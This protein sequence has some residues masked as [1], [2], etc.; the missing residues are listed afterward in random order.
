[1]F[2]LTEIPPR[3]MVAP[4]GAR[5]GKADNPN[6]PISIEEIRNEAIACAAAGADALHLHIR[7]DAGNHSLD[8]GRYQEAISEIHTTLPQFPIQITTESAGLFDVSQQFNCLKMLRPKA[9]SISV[10]EIARDRTLAPEVYK[11]CSSENIHVQHILYDPKD[12]LQ[13]EEWQN[14]DIVKMGQ[15]DTIFVLGSYT[16]MKAALIADLQD[17]EPLIKAQKG[18]KMVCAFGDN[19]HEVLCAAAAMGFDLRIGFENN[20]SA[21]DGSLAKSNAENVAELKSAINR[22]SP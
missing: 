9:T 17:L 19:E 1:M 15:E 6:I 5:R 16:P 20:I 11:F 18:R 2:A 12:L 13:L 8:P 22:L 4:N 14:K 10:R 21:R 7:D 3:I